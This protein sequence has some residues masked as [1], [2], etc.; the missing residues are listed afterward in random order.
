MMRKE[1]F[2]SLLFCCFALLSCNKHENE[3]STIGNGKIEVSIAQSA[4][5]ASR[6][7]ISDDN[8]SAVWSPG[9]K[10]A[11]WAKATDGSYA[12]T[13]EAFTLYHFTQS[14]SRAV[15]SAYIN[16]M[17]ESTYTYYATHPT[18]T[19]CEGTLATFSVPTEQD[20]SAFVG[21]CDI[22]VAE[23]I[24]GGALQG[25]QVKNT[26]FRFAHKMHALKIKIPEGGNLLEM[27]I[28]RIEFTFPT[29]VVGDVTVDI[30]DPLAPATLTNGSR[31][32]NV[33]IPNGA[34]EDSVIW[35]MIFPSEL[36][37]EITYTAFSGSYKS[38]SRTI[39]I[40]KATEA[41]HVTPM[42]IV[43]PELYRLTTISFY[44]N[45]NLLGEDIKKV[46]I[47]DEAGS[48]VVGTTSYN[49]A[50]GRFEMIFN[51]TFDDS[52]YSNKRFMACFESDHAKVY[53]AFTM[54]TVTPYIESVNA[55]NVPYLFFEDFSGVSDISANDTYGQYDSDAGSKSAVSFCNGWTGARMGASAGKAVRLAARRETTARYPSRM[56]S[57]PLSGITSPTKLKVMFN[58]GMNRSEGGIYMTPPGLGLTCYFG[59]VT[60]N[61]AYASGDE[62]GTFAGG[63]NTFALNAA[64]ATYDLIMESATLY[65]DNCGGSTRLTWRIVPDD[66]SDLSNGTYY[67]YLDNVIV[68]IAQ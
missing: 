34:V 60:S 64:S 62:T 13:A 24:E 4:N 54:T 33:N 19:S 32:L 2:L 9:D 66:K 28:T 49:A 16:P 22:M 14:F 18:P 5:I 57:A 27:P 25:N 21:G 68:Q 37:G 61:D 41:A 55:L 12:L 7:A 52:P 1:H 35:A 6:T 26:N 8:G 30:T 53:N 59:Y 63:D 36:S 43:I 45:S 65:L 56:D 38:F 17:S 15:F 39:T 51:G 67:L 42:S 29:E 50:T 48:S 46:T 10:I 20:G 11:I 31:Q 44:I 47:L 58:Y 3:S 40:D 23:P